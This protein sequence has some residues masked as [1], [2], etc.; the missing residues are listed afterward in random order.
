MAEKIYVF[1]L[2]WHNKRIHIV[3]TVYFEITQRLVANPTKKR[4][5]L[6]NTTTK[7]LEIKT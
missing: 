7:V 1:V 3:N 6:P 4:T 2:E 5:I